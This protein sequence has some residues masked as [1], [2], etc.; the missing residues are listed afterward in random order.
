MYFAWDLNPGNLILK[1]DVLELED[2]SRYLGLA[3]ACSE[4]EQQDTSHRWPW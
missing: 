3:G 2:S 1:G 4:K